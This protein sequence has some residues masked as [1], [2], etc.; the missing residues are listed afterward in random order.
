MAQ[1]DNTRPGTLRAVLGAARTTL[2]GAGRLL[3]DAIVPAACVAC[4]TPVATYDELCP[5]C[6]RQIAFIRKPLC[7]RLGLPMSFATGEVMISAAAAARP[8]AYGRA[9]GVAVFD[10]VMRDLIHAFKYADRHDARRL[11]GRWLAG[12]GAEL[13]P[14]SDVLVPVPL[15]RWR[16]LR[17]QFN[18]AAI[19]AQELS[20]RTGVPMLP[21]A[22]RRTRATVSQVGLSHDERRRNV[23]GAF[24]VSARRAASVWQRSVLLVDDVITTGATAEACARALLAAGASRVDVLA[25]ALVT[26]PSQASP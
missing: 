8:P 11:F 18:Q 9:R 22:L 2:V 17:R 21:D 23:G 14:Q 12:A 15:A 4:R 3:A 25:L 26:D 24:A 20:A 1:S 10:G 5:A 6:W 19:L 16:L 13:L 7:D